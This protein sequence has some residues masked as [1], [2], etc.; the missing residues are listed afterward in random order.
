MFASIPN[1]N[2][3][4]IELD[5]NN[6]GV[7][8]LRLLNEIIADFD[9]VRPCSSIS[10]RGSRDDSSWTQIL[11]AS[12]VSPLGSRTAVTVKTEHMDSKIGTRAGQ[13]PLRV[14]RWELLGPSPTRLCAFPSTEDPLLPS[15]YELGFRDVDCPMLP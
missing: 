12:A 1:F 15:D 4:Y 7:E 8:C 13:L 5:G 6:M 3:F 11:L 2:D 10:L 9:E 14:Y